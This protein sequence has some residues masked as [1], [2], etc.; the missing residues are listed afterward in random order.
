MPK[1][2]VP[3]THM[4]KRHS[5]QHSSAWPPCTCTYNTHMYEYHEN[6]S[7]INIHSLT[8]MP[9]QLP[10]CMKMT[11]TIYWSRCNYSLYPSDFIS[12]R[13]WRVEAEGSGNTRQPLPTVSRSEGHNS[14]YVSTILLSM[15]NLLNFVID[16]RSCR[17]S[18][19]KHPDN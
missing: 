8:P 16:K 5:H 19:S 15:Q 13:T 17:S 9:R 12:Y 11:D 14:R 1:M 2:C 10:L 6:K 4:P 3:E 18:R 7:P